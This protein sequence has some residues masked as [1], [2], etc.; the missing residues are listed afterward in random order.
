[1]QDL[2]CV[3]AYINDILIRS[4]GTYEDHLEKTEKVLIRLEKAGW[5]V[6]VCRSVFAVT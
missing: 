2:D 3:W 5:A 4:N 6:N 1:M